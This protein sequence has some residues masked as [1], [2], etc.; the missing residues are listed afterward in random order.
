MHDGALHVE[1]EFASVEVVVPRVEDIDGSSPCAR[2]PLRASPRV[3]VQLRRLYY[4]SP[5]FGNVRYYDGAWNRERVP[6]PVRGVG[7]LHG[8]LAFPNGV[9]YILIALIHLD[10][11]NDC[12]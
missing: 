10:C 12:D 2:V 1:L 8:S 7:F 4:I 3:G 6:S 11:S 5:W 9:V